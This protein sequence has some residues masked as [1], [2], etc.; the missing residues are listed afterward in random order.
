MLLLWLA[1]AAPPTP[2]LDTGEAVP[3]GA[4][5]FALPL[6]EP[7]RFYQTVGVDHDPVAYDGGLEALI[8]EDYL[9]RSFPW[10]YDGHDGSDYLLD[11]GF[12]AM[13][14]G[15]PAVLAAAAGVVVSVADGNYDRCHGDMATGEVSCDGYPMVANHVI[16]EHAS[17]DR[18]LYWHLQR[19]SVAVVL[20]QEVAC[21]AHLGLVGSSG[22]SSAPHLHFELQDATGT[23]LD[24]YAGPR[25]Q[26]ETWWEEQG[27]PE[28]LPGAGCG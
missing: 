18:S 4:L 24:P 5:R 1:C 27:D 23:A 25:S 11:G 28:G 3:R 8:C 7:E 9:G 15:S 16:L 17:G 20:G 22:N 10:C 26:P 14:A 6:A 19:D 21:G 13:D 12:E 2:P